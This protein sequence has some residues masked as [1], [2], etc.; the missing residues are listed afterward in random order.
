[1]AANII[2]CLDDL[3]TMSIHNDSKNTAHDFK[4]RV[5]VIYPIPK[6]FWKKILQESS[7]F[8]H[9]DLFKQLPFLNKEEIKEI[10]LFDYIKKYIP[11]IEKFDPTVF[12]DT[13]LDSAMGPNSEFFSRPHIRSETPEKFII[14][15]FYKYRTDTNFLLPEF[16]TSWEIT[17]DKDK[18][19]VNE[20]NNVRDITRY[21]YYDDF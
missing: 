19:E 15:V 5:K 3:L 17:V 16:K 12:R 14:I 2:I 11:A 7:F 18:I 10:E 13:L 4:F 6:S 21:D 20:R 9:I 1:M 8:Y